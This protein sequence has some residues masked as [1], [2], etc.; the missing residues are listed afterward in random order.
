ML[1]SKVLRRHQ[2]VMQVVPKYKELSVNQVWKHVKESPELNKYFPNYTAAQLPNR[3]FMY[4][5]VSTIYP[6]ALRS[7][8][9]DSRKNRIETHED[10]K[11]ELIDIDADYKN[12]IMNILTLKGNEVK[13]YA[14]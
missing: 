2:A 6:K 8:I 14:L 13:L 12:E 9:E 1:I 5:I 11:D 7:L 10:D 4:A 3:E